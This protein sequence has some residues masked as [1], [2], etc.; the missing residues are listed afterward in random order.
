MK[1]KL[2][3]FIKDEDGAETIEFIGLICVAAALIVVIINIGSSISE[4]AHN[5]QNTMETELDSVIN[6]SYDWK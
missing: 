2:I 6:K 3:N 1:N 5:A 4:Y